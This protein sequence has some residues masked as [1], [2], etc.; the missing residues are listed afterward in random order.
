MLHVPDSQEPQV[1]GRR[2][3]AVPAEEPERAKRAPEWA[4]AEEHF[5]TDGNRAGSRSRC[6]FCL[7]RLASLLN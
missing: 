3:A 4:R 1:L 5:V 2:A 6:A 7:P